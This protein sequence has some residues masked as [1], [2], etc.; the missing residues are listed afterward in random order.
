LISGITQGDCGSAIVDQETYEIYGHIIGSNRNGHGL[1]APLVDT[2]RQIKSTFGTARVRLPTIDYNIEQRGVE[3]SPMVATS[4]KQTIGSRL[5]PINT[6]S[7]RTSDT[8]AQS[9][10]NIVRL[11][12][13]SIAVTNARYLNHVHSLSKRISRAS[14]LYHFLKCLRTAQKPPKTNSHLRYCVD[15]V[16]ECLTQPEN[17][18]Y[19]VEGIFV[20]QNSFNT[21]QGA[22]LKLFTV[23]IEIGYERYIAKFLSSHRMHDLVPVYSPQEIF[24]RKEF[25]AKFTLSQDKIK[26]P[27]RGSMDTRTTLDWLI[28]EADPPVDRSSVKRCWEGILELMESISD[29]LRSMN[30]YW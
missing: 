14:I 3:L 30:G 6:T 24:P 8:S 28:A 13:G 18:K 4:K 15:L 1:I 10:L 21:A 19:L 5:Q 2:I 11:P 25:T 20:D 7:S 12:P 17:L 27:E 16:R 9:K 22:D 26:V 23:L 29:N